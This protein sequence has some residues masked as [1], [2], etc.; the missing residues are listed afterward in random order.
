MLQTYGVFLAYY[1]NTNQSPGYQARDYAFIEG[2][3]FGITMLSAVSVTVLARK[4]GMPEPDNLASS[5]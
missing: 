5:C 4:L 2:I 3:D 1:L